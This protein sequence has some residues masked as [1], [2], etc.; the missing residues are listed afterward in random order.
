[1]KPLPPPLV[2]VVA[3]PG[4][5]TPGARAPFPLL[6]SRSSSYIF[7]AFVNCIMNVELTTVC[8]REAASD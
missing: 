1:M 2:N 7:I 5:G 8:F 6:P 3:D 4:E